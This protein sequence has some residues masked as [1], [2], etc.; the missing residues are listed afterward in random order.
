MSRLPLMREVD[1]CEAKR[2]RERKIVTVSPPVSPI[3][4]TAPSSEGAKALRACVSGQRRYTISQQLLAFYLCQQRFFFIG[5]LSV[6]DG[7]QQQFQRLPDFP[8]PQAEGQHIVAIH[9][10]LA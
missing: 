7:T 2:R 8:S 10:Q 1:F 9:R 6:H 5:Q 4:E 3:G